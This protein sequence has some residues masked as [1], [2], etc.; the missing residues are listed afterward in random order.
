[1]TP[2][3]FKTNPDDYDGVGQML[4]WLYNKIDSSVTVNAATT[5]TDWKNLGVFR[6]FDQTEFI[7]AMIPFE[8]HGLLKR[9]WVYYPNTCKTAGSNCKV[10]MALH[11]CGG[12]SVTKIGLTGEIWPFMKNYGYMHYAA[13]N[14][15]IMIFPQAKQDLFFLVG[16]CFDFQGKIHWDLS[17]TKESPQM[18]ALKRMFDRVSARHGSVKTDLDANNI[19]TYYGNKLSNMKIWWTLNEIPVFISHRISKLFVGEL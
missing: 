6:E 2:T 12:A 11:G 14:N 15:I 3:I 4:T 9:G 13:A 16:E 18:R 17:Y 8:Q 1:M 7:D 19:N 10:H 5:S